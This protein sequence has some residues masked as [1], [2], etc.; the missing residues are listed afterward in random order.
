MAYSSKTE[1][2]RKV[3]ARSPTKLAGNWDAALIDNGDDNDDGI[4]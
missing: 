3:T 4:K 1:L 2:S